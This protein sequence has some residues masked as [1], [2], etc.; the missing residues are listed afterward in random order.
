[1]TN[2]DY[3]DYNEEETARGTVTR[4]VPTGIRQR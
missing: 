1:M 2:V 4:R 3:K